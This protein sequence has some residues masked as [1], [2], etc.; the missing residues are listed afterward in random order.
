MGALKKNMKLF[1]KSFRVFLAVLVITGVYNLISVDF[2]LSI[3]S[4]LQD[5]ID[6]QNRIPPPIFCPKGIILSQ[7]SHGINCIDDCK[8]TYG[9]T[10]YLSHNDLYNGVNQDCT[11]SDAACCCVLQHWP[12]SCPGGLPHGI[13]APYSFIDRNNITH[14]MG[15]YMISPTTMKQAIT[16]RIFTLPTTPVGQTVPDPAPSPPPGGPSPGGATSL[17]YINPIGGSSSS[18]IGR[19]DF[20]GIIGMV[21]KG[22]LGLMG[23]TALLVFVY[24]GFL[25][26]FARGDPNEVKKGFDTMISA[27]AG[28]I[29]I[30]GSYA[31]LQRF[32][33]ILPH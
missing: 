3:D 5:A 20:H 16:G 15:I 23:T 26:L 21:L 4:D 28:L 25:W 14:D 27:G 2:A 6:M 22:I 1:F 17:I 19:I 31:I 29:I 33:E 11:A 8:N 12:S 32:F 10:G 9:G 24:G 13:G 18:P 30:F 7:I